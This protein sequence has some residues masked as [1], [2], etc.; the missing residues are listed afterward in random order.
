VVVVSYAAMRRTH[1]RVAGWSLRSYRLVGVAVSAPSGRKE[2]HRSDSS[3]RV[4]L[5][6]AGVATVVTLRPVQCGEDIGVNPVRRRG[7]LVLIQTWRRRTR[8]HSDSRL[9]RR[10]DNPPGAARQL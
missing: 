3:R 2:L 4:G 9:M 1:M 7:G 10:A 8:N 6:R 5:E